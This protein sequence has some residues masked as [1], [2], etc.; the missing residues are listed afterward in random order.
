MKAYR[1]DSSR[2]ISSPVAIT[3]IMILS[4]FVAFYSLFIGQKLIDTAPSSP[5]FNV[6]KRIN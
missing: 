4:L 5:V 3:V 1:F 6:E 2:N